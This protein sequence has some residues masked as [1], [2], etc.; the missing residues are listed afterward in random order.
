M[1]TIFT[2]NLTEYHAKYYAYELT[3]RCSSDS[4]NKL[5]VSLSD[6]QVDL[7]PHQIEAALFAFKSPLSKG[8][9][10]ADEVG[11]G[12]T[13]EAGIIISQKWAE[14]KR[15]ILTI[16]PANLRKQWNEELMDKFFIPSIILEK[17]SFNEEIAKGNLNPL[18]QEEKIVICSYH[19]ARGK[20]AYIKQTKW[21]LI[22][23][24]EAHR[25]R[26]VYKDSNKIAKAIKS[27]VKDFPKILLTATPL[28]NSLLELF[29]LVS[30]VDEKVFGDID[31]FK[32]RY[33]KDTPN[34]DELKDRIRPICQRTLRRQVLEY[35]NFTNR[36]AITQEFFP[37]EEEQ[38]LYNVVTTYLQRPILYALPAGQRHLMTLILRKLLAS[39]THAIAGTLLGLAYKLEF[40]LKNQ[41][42]PEVVE[43]ILHQE[44]E[45][46]DELK[47]EWIDD[48]EEDEEE[49]PK[50]PLKLTEKDIQSIKE[51]IALL[52]E[53]HNV[54]EKIVRNSKGD[55]LLT[56][57]NKGF[58]EAQKKGASKKAI[59]FTEST[60]TQAY[61]LDILSQTEYAGKVV[62][63]NGTNNNATAKTILREW[64][65]KNKDTDRVTGSST[66]N[67]RAALVD[68]FKDDAVIMIA[69]EAAAEGINLQ[70]CS[71]VVNYDL[72]WNP[73]RIEQRIGRCHRYGQKHD[74]VV[75]NFLNKKNAADVRV[76][77][78]LEKKFCIFSGV[79]G[80]SD[81]VLGAIESGVDFERRI[82]DIYQSCRTEEEIQRS[83]DA[84][85][86]ELETKISERVTQTKQ[87][88]LESFDEE[89][90]EKLRINVA[91]SKEFLGKF[92]NW[93]WSLTKF[94]LK[95]NAQF[96]DK[97]KKFVLVNNPFP[98]ETIYPG[99]YRLGKNVEDSHVYR[100]SHPLAERIIKECKAF[101][102]PLQELVFSYSVN[103]KKISI[104]EPLVGKSGWLA[105]SNLTISSF[106]DEDHVLCCAIS[107]EGKPLDS[108]HV[109]RLFS[110]P[111][112]ANGDGMKISSDVTGRLSQIAEV[113]KQEIIDGILSRNSGFFDKEM[114][115]LEKWAD[116]LKESMEIEIKDLDRLIKM[117]KTE[118]KKILTLE[119]KVKSQREIK[120]MEKKR[121]AMRVNYF[122][123]QD[124]IDE[125]KEQLI[126]QVEARLKQKIAE[127][128]IFTIRWSLQ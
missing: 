10:L 83:F 128:E 30:V 21:D 24:D 117:N 114:E 78:L 120:D 103:N 41:N 108:E 33:C 13:I 86:N 22:I 80:A 118:A 68:R 99:P 31:S 4:L 76:Y 42:K 32:A 109:Q 90:S 69:T 81:E 123:E 94:Y 47:E 57:L 54:A 38:I 53:M 45:S 84:L 7:N 44:L 96:D 95:E 16:V 17:G 124:S 40:L 18:N 39:S 29:G 11:L 77:E 52:K 8:A 100:P 79:F 15:K 63:F 75:V 43:D 56:A 121:N 73:Q 5:A 19:F 91:Q 28:Q 3:K 67:M 36:I 59:I 88:L 37:R 89:V 125:R 61:L 25:L 50:Q 26:N 51:E 2:E 23:I 46:Y 62:L 66:A 98:N 82:A 127:K 58:E 106:E 6:A 92:E 1:K 97:E 85:Q 55:V 105:F 20:D 87:R 48:D 113:R 107:D 74:V 9:I 60:R 126:A 115:K 102:T 116:D 119:D 49:E 104:L 72:P 110:L 101:S 34:L 12:K 35:I 65:E 71:L 111:A 27:A 14:R 70:F 122:K 112:V 64:V 93:L